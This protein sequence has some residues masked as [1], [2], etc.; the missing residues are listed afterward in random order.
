M[1]SRWN[2]QVRMM[3]K[4]QLGTLTKELYQ[5]AIAA[6]RKVGGAERLFLKKAQ[7]PIAVLFA[8]ISR[9]VNGEPIER[10]FPCEHFTLNLH[11]LLAKKLNG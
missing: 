5:N 8:N 9:K 11:M 1:N 7:S 10:S 6:L 2:V 4:E 3:G